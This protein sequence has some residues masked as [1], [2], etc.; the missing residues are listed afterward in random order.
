MI[1]EAN[2]QLLLKWYLSYRFLPKTEEV[3]TL[4]YVQGGGRKG[5]SAIDQA[6][7]QII[8]PEVIHLCQTTAIDLYLHLH[9]CFNMMVKHVTI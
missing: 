8:E 7:Q 2:W 5:C 6:A 1:F 9:Q 3:G 4:V